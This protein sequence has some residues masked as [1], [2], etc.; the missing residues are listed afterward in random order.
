MNQK[1]NKSLYNY[2]SSAIVDGSL[3]EDFSLPNNNNDNEIS[4]MDGALDGVTIFHTASSN[5][6]EEQISI[7]K[8]AVATASEANFDKADKLFCELGQKV[9]AISVIDDIQSY[10]IENRDS[11]SA[12]NIYNY[13]IHAIMYSADTECVKFGFCLLEL[14][15]T[16]NSNKLKDIVRTM[17]LSDEFSIF[18]IF[19]MQ[20][21]TD[22]NNEV[23]QLAQKIH[24]WGRIH[25]VERI[26]PETNEI[27]EWLLRDGVHNTIL[28]AYSAL[29]CWQKSNAESI[30]KGNISSADFSGIRDLIQGLI[31]EGPVPGISQLENGTEIITT[32]LNKAKNRELTDADYDVIQNI[33]AYYEDDIA[34]CDIIDL[35]KEIINLKGKEIKCMD[36]NYEE[37]AG[38]AVEY[39]KSIDI[40]LDF[41]K[42]SIN[43]VEDILSLY[44]EHLDEYRG[45]EGA[46]ALWNIAVHFGIYIGETMLK[47]QL[48]D[49]GYEWYIDGS[50][51]VLKNGNNVCS[52]ITKAHKRIL[53]GPED[54]VKSFCDVAF[55]MA[56]GKF[57]NTNVLR[58]VDVELASGKS[59]DNVPYKGIDRFIMLVEN[60]D[61]DFVILKSHDGFLQFYGYKNQFVG[62]IRVN[63]PDNDFRVYSIIDKA[64]EDLTE[65]IS[66]S[67][68][69]G[70]F[71]P[72]DREVVSL[73]IIRG[74]VKSYYENP[75]EDEFLKSICYVESTEFFK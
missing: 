9:R 18:A 73:E 64:K 34:N 61:E 56:D 20:S 52:P 6:T 30:L 36:I 22:G 19:I 74:T 40:K 47:L 33:L 25:A 46:D 13:A 75:S 7:M 68:P 44:N 72:T 66:I 11:L 32:F 17:G 43:S 41:S 16:D 51:P 49:K 28:P 39:A 67:T 69:Y 38:K 24:G 37:I 42:E 65:R 71:T 58:A 12:N 57:P 4:W 59:F 5:M 14:F 55:L 63:L 62:E 8:N 2:I 60:G 10:I 48:K 23:F 54:N 15:N 53:N 35:C 3:P 21:W 29:I 31:D 70:N 45:E 26:E 50:L 1:E 27:K